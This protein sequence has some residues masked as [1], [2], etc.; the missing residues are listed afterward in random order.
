[1]LIAILILFSVLFKILNKFFGISTRIKDG[2]AILAY[3]LFPYVIGLIILFTI[4]VTVFGGNIFLE[5]I[6]HHLA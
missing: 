6:L 1:M 2:I 3:S 4:E 5:I